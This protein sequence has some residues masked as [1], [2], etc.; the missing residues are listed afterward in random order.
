MSSVFSCLHDLDK[1]M[2]EHVYGVCIDLHPVLANDEGTKTLL[3]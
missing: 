1:V 3:V 2:E